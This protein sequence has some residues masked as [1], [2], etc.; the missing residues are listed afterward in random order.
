MP[1]LSGWISIILGSTLVAVA[2]YYLFH[3]FPRIVKDKNL[4]I[5]MTALRFSYWLGISGLVM[6][7]LGVLHFMRVIPWWS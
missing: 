7:F 2:C 3:A 4:P 6:L 5:S 1:I